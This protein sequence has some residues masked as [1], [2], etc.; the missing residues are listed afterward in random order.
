MQTV[1]YREF[2]A[3]PELA[4][5]V[6]CNWER[7]RAPGDGDAVQRVVPDAC[8]DLVWRGSRL[9]IAGPDTTA[10][11]SPVEAGRTVVGLRFRPGVA[12]T[13]LGLPAGALRDLRVPLE[14]VWGRDGA[15][16][17]ER[18]DSAA[19]ARERRQ[20]LQDAVLRRR[21]TI[22][23]PDEIVL[24]ACRL[25][26]RPRSRVESVSRELATSERHL[27]RR[28]RDAVGYG[29]KTYNRVVRFQRFLARYRAAGADGANLAATAA[30]LGYADQAHLTRDCVEL[31]GL[32]PTALARGLTATA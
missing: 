6:A 19:T 31:S 25:L 20:L 15:E 27:R 14:D 12:G 13:A 5:L 1:S 22:D 26:G 30:E 3:R 11:L 18:V 10:F 4:D 17:A 24:A 8:V 2:R 7:G 16:L 23:D 32:T 28:F 9:W 21:G 29:P